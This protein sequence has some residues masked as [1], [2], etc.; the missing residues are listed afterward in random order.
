MIFTA[1]VLDR[2]LTELAE[3]VAARDVEVVIHVVGGSA[4]AIGYNPDRSATRDVDAWVN[5]SSAA[6]AV[7]LDV[8]AE[9]ANENGWPSDWLN[10]N[11]VMFIPEAVGGS[12]SAHWRSYRTAGKVD[13]VVATPDVLFAMKIHAARGRRDLPDLEVLAGAAGVST[14]AA[15]V[16]LFELYYPPDALKPASVQV[17]AGP[18]DSRRPL[19]TSPQGCMYETTHP[20]YNGS[21]CGDE[22]NRTPDIYLAKVA[23]C[24]LSY[25]PGRTITIAAQ[26][27]PHTRQKPASIETPASPGRRRRAPRVP[28]RTG[29][30]HH[31]GG[32]LP[33]RPR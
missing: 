22:G 33:H 23:L 8:A 10:E 21:I 2:V 5:A 29:R 7:V 17:D 16:E 31:R 4:V 32:T 9:L 13:V 28:P 18:E 20:L 3:R 15:A 11:A 12:G 26:P 30:A 14:A 6:K 25:V 19:S 27:P 24:Q 1:D